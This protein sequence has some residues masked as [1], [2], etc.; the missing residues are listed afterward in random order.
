MLGP[1]PVWLKTVQGKHPAAPPCLSEVSWW[2]A[3]LQIGFPEFAKKNEAKKLNKQNKNDS[4]RCDTLYTVCVQSPIGSDLSSFGSA[5][6]CYL[7]P[8][9]SW[10]VSCLSLLRPADIEPMH[11][12]KNLKSKVSSATTPAAK[13]LLGTGRTLHSPTNEQ[14]G[15]REAGSGRLDLALKGKKTIGYLRRKYKICL[16]DKAVAKHVQ[17]SNGVG[18]CWISDRILH[19][20]DSQWSFP[21]SAIG[22]RSCKT[23]GHYEHL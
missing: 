20:K 4:D 11:G 1:T 16:Q 10:S 3:F 2:K 9:F 6:C 22:C 5:K 13:S 19:F 15:S 18:Y 21:V 8:A 23:L 14:Q 12:L 17:V 7:F